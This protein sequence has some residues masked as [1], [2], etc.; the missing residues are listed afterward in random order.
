MPIIRC[1]SKGTRFRRSHCALSLRSHLQWHVASCED[2]LQQK[3]A[4]GFKHHLDL[5]STFDHFSESF[6]TLLCMYTRL[7]I[8]VD[9]LDSRTFRT[10]FVHNI[11]P[12][13]PDCRKRKYKEENETEQL[14]LWP[15]HFYSP[16]RNVGCSDPIDYVRHE[17]CQ[18]PGEKMQKK[19]RS[20]MF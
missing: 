19:H 4:L 13:S 8:S 10:F 17:G 7:Q 20:F 16:P 15:L 5:M 14:L 9:C 12:H 6:R 1:F 2:G 18:K 3:G 11:V